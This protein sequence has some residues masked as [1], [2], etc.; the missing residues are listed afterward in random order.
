MLWP[1]THHCP[2]ALSELFTNDK[3]SSSN[4]PD[5]LAAVDTFLDAAPDAGIVLCSDDGAPNG[6]A[7]AA[8]EGVHEKFQRRY[9]ARVV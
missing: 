1:L 2:A 5:A 9:G 4:T 3:Y 6:A 8:F 7:A